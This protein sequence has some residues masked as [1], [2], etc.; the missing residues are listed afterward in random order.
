MAAPGAIDVGLAAHRGLGDPE[1]GAQL[2]GGAVQLTGSSATANPLASLDSGPSDGGPPERRI[3]CQLG[4]YRSSEALMPDMV[5]GALAGHSDDH[6]ARPR[7]LARYKR[8]H[9]AVS[10]MSSNGVP[11]QQISDTVGRKSTQVTETVY[12]DVIMP[13]S[14]AGRPS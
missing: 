11:L 9:T 1:G 8:R 3:L 14:E 12:R 7:P 5:G 2:A 10:I 13:P 4:S 6:L